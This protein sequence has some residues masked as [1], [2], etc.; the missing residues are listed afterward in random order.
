[1]PLSADVCYAGCKGVIEAL[2]YVD[3][4]YTIIAARVLP[5]SLPKMEIT[6][7]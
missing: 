3:I 7:M 6:Q 4:V 1:M 2:Y 5:L